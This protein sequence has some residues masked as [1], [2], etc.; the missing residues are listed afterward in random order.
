MG[1]EKAA[2]GCLREAD[3]SMSR[4]LPLG[5]AEVGTSSSF[6]PRLVI[7]T[8]ACLPQMPGSRRADM[9]IP[10]ATAPKRRS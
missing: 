9:I 1:L 10:R 8:A 4:G 2:V 5:E 6:E 7:C 3:V